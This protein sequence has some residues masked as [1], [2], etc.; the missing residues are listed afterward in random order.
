MRKL[1]STLID[2]R[3]Q[4]RLLVSEKAVCVENLLYRY[5]YQPSLEENENDGNN[6]CEYIVHVY[7]T[8]SSKNP[9]SREHVDNPL[10]SAWSGG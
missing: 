10:T 7:K 1:V 6:L 5:S 4:N 9:L 3:K 8:Y 2:F